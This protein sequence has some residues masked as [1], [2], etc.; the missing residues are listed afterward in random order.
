MTSGTPTPTVAQS[1][2]AFDQ[3]IGVNVHMG[4]YWTAYNDVSLVEAD[5]AYLGVNHVRDELLD[6]S[7]VQTN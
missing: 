7:N 1:A 5:L 3:S 4:Y 2:A 6:W